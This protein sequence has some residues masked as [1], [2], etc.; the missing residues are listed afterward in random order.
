MVGTSHS[1]KDKT[2]A[3]ICDLGRLGGN[4]GQQS[5]DVEFIVGDEKTG[6]VERFLAH[7]KVVGSVLG[8]LQEEVVTIKDVTGEAFGAL[9]SYLYNSVDSG[10]SFLSIHGLLQLFMLAQRLSLSDL[11]SMVLERVEA[12]PLSTDNIVEVLSSTDNLHHHHSK[13]AMLLHNRLV[14]FLSIHLKHES[15]LAESLLQH[16]SPSTGEVVVPLERLLKLSTKE[17]MVSFSSSVEELVFRTDSAIQSKTVKNRRKAEKKRKRLEKRLS[18]S[19]QDDSGIA[20]SFEDS[21]PWQLG[22]EGDLNMGPEGGLEEDA[23]NEANLELI[24]NLDLGK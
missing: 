9:L 24:F 22:G 13:A 6:K 3:V 4:M 23:L 8:P 14:D 5:P 7:R 15:Q 17:K 10:F 18:E 21:S 16:F 2:D 12:V 1:L 20:S 19:S 11:A